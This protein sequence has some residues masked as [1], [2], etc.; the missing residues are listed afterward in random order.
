MK[1]HEYQ[2]AALFAAYGVRV[3]EGQMAKTAAEAEAAARA[4]GEGPFVIKA[5][6]H[7][8]GRGKAGGVKFANTP[9]EAAEKA[10]EI[11]GMTLV[12]KQTGPQGRVVQKVLVSRA[13]EIAREYYLSLTVDGARERGLSGYYLKPL[14]GDALAAGN[15]LARGGR[16]L[17]YGA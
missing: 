2:A 13:M 12:T 14:A 4:L 9:E 11:L 17:P 15:L 10:K 7:S 5:Q 6:V 16:G 8:G 1:I 3:P